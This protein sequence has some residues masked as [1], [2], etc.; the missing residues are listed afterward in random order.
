MF[1]AVVWLLKL[2][3]EKLRDLALELPHTYCKSWKGPILEHLESFLQI[4][5]TRLLP[6][7]RSYH[8]GDNWTVYYTVCN[9]DIKNQCMTMN[10][11]F[12]CMCSVHFPLTS[13]PSPITNVS[14]RWKQNE[15]HF[16]TR[17]S[18]TEMGWKIRP[19][20]GPKPT[21][22]GLVL[23]RYLVRKCGNCSKKFK[24]C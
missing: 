1:H 22:L 18:L 20:D 2:R 11:H 15:H 16:I 21:W 7:Q 17:C 19:V 23:D 8:F 12:K 9:R 13:L 5:L 4:F 14:A 3:L 24:L 6:Y 10:R